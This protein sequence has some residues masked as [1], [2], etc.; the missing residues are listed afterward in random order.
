MRIA[1]NARFLVEQHL[2]G[3]G[4]YTLEILR[5]LL[6][7]TDH[8]FLLLTDRAG[9]L[10]SLPRPVERV[11]L[12]PSA[13]HPVLFL[14]WFEGAVP[15]AL[16]K[17]GADGFLSMD[18]FCSLRTRVPTVLV[19]HDLAY[20]H[21]PDGV[22]PL[23]LRYYQRMMP[24][25]VRRADSLVAVSK[26]T[27]LDLSEAFHVSAA[28]IRV[29]YNGLRPRFGP[30]SLKRIASVR[31]ATTGGQPYFLYVG[32]IHP[33]KNVG[34]LIGAFDRFVAAS[35]APHRLVI[36]GSQAWQTEPVEAA[37][38]AS[39]NRARI[40]F[41]GFLPEAELGDLIGAAEALALVS[42]FEGFG[43]PLLEAMACGVPVVASNV[44]SM[45]EVVGAAGL[46]VDP[47]SELEIALALG[48][49]AGSEPLRR[50]FAEA[51][52]A[53]AATFTWERGA[54]VIAEAIDSL[55]A[56]PDSFSDARQ[57]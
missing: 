8:E 32:A 40:R 27:R 31:N 26:A 30:L 41:T 25:Y 44:S 43:V 42:L 45:P 33:R 17:W 5:A 51:G 50:R 56:K 7:T 19:V 24:R 37:Y 12:Y 35:G 16:R 23:M 20:R 48:R 53:R 11:T 21:V 57:T 14:A 18:N 36:A 34:R 28:D 15:R 49:L 54:A 9:P 4:R 3:I 52:L 46:L 1:L 2:E 10:P 39:P 22:S 6:R 29:A 55:G 47:T 13:R 38:A